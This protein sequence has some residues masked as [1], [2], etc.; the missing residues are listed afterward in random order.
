MDVALRALAQVFLLEVVYREQ[1]LDIDHLVKV[2]RDP[3]EL[4]GDVAAQ[5][6]RDLEVVTADRQIHE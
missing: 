4:G 2:T 1:D 5:G 3:F 6:G